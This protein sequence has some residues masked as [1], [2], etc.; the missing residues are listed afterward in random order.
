MPRLSYEE[1]KSK[2][3][4]VLKNAGAPLTWTEIRTKAALPQAFPNNQW[5]RRME[6]DIG[7]VRRRE[8]SGI[9]HWGLNETLFDVS[10]TAPV[11]AADK[12]S[13]STGR[14]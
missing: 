3:A 8:G 9:I 14:K 5:V 10:S 7:L 12:A 4:K 13:A 6:V 11:K 1:F 2:I